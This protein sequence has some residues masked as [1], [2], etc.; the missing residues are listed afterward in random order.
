[1]NHAASLHVLHCSCGAFLESLTREGIC[2]NCGRRIEVEVKV[3]SKRKLKRIDYFGLL[4]IVLFAVACI[5]GI[6][7]SREKLKT[8]QEQ[9]QV[10]P[11]QDGSTVPK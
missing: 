4:V 7:S 6:L 2:W 11:A 5:G 10:I 9:Q 3:K 1:V 8:Q